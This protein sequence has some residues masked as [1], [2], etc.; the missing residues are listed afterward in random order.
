MNFKSLKKCDLLLLL[1][2]IA[3]SL[4]N[5]VYAQAI[6]ADPNKPCGS[7]KPHELPFKVPPSQ[8][9]ARAEDRSA[10]FYAIILKSAK[11]C[12]IS[13]VE[14]QSTQTL[15]P[16]NKVF[17]SRFECEPEDNITYSTIDHTKHAILAVY[18]GAT[19]RAAATFLSHVRRT[20]RFPDAYVRKMAVALVHP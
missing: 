13:E 15:F 10:E 11:P 2:L 18:A 3:P 12:S 14:R 16:R 19:K 20:G 17:L 1:V 5:S 9:L 4:S 7:F 6:C 8:A